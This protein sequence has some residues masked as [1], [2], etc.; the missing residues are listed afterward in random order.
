MLL[1]GIVRQF[2]RVRV[3][4]GL[5]LVLLA[6]V[7]FLLACHELFDPDVWW[8]IRGGQWI[9]AHRGVPG[10]DPFTFG[11]ADRVWV[12]LHWI[13]EV[14][15]SYAYEGGGVPALIVVTAMTA[16]AAFVTAQT[17]TRRGAF[18]V[19]A[20]V[21]W[22][23][24]LVLMS[25]R[26][27]PRPEVLSMLFLAAFVTI[28]GRARQFPYWLWLLPVLQ[29]LWVNT[30]ALFVLG[31]LVL[32]SEILARLIN[33][34]FGTRQIDSDHPPTGPRAAWHLGAVSLAVVAACL[35][36]PYGV[37]GA[38]FPLLLYPKVT[39]AG[40]IY[41]TYIAE[42][43]TLRE[44]ATTTPGRMGPGNP[45]VR[46]TYFLL[47]ALPISFVVPAVVR[48]CGCAPYGKAAPRSVAMPDPSLSAGAWLG[49]FGIAV[50]LAVV[51]A[52]SLPTPQT[53]IWLLVTGEAVPIGLGLLGVVGYFTLQRRSRT[54]AI[55]ALTGA[56]LVAAWS[57]W[58][59]AYLLSEQ[60]TWVSATT[61]IV[62]AL[63][64]PV[65]LLVMRWG[66]NPFR[67]I[68]AVAFGYLGLQAIRNAGLFGLVS[69]VLLACNVAD[70]AQRCVP[71]DRYSRSLVAGLWSLRIGLAC[72]LAVWIGTLLGGQYYDWTDQARRIGL[73]ERPFEFAHDAVR[74]ATQPGMPAR[75][76]VTGIGHTGLFDFHGPPEH[77]PYI[78]ARLELPERTTF[79]NYV[80]IEKWLRQHDARWRYALS[81]LDCQQILLVHRDDNA[82]AEA[83]LLA[84][85]DWRCV[86]FDAMAAVFVSKVSNVDTTQFPA[87]D[88]GRRLFTAA[89][90]PVSPDQSG[91]ALREAK[92][93]YAMGMSL[94]VPP[95]SRW[96][97]RAPLL[98]LALRRAQ[99]A[100]D[101][102]PNDGEPWLIW[103]SVCQGLAPGAPPSLADGWDAARV[104][105]W[106][107]ATYGFREA[108]AKSPGSRNVLNRLYNAYWARQMADAQLALGEQLQAGRMTTP[109]QDQQIAKLRQFLAQAPRRRDSAATS[110]SVAI[111]ALLDNHQPEAAS[112]VAL[113]LESQLGQGFDWQTADRIGT[114][115][116]H[117]GQ[118]A[119]ARRFWERAPSPAD[120]LCRVAAT[121]WV[122]RQ[123]QT[124]EALYREALTHNAKAPEAWWGLAMLHAEMGDAEPALRACRAALA[125]SLTESQR[126]SLQDLEPLLSRYVTMKGID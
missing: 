46:A 61:L 64:V 85:P 72:V 73:R 89:E 34:W 13:F 44:I 66:G 55:L 48:A 16:T 43:A 125:L 120:R 92:A 40:N 14:L 58:L 105:P 41:K 100:A 68:L 20:A 47:L 4:D 26:F 30:H 56:L 97:R 84:D 59:R 86:Y 123:W 96:Q 81:D 22:I 5:L 102:S 54:S 49:V 38:V 9:R 31:P 32:G 117:L 62:V 95:E 57:T 83:E 99:H 19:V 6:A 53:P 124:A 36:N 119:D 93:L 90:S 107:Q 111:A 3:A 106:A 116:M 42:F 7:C 18:G 114:T 33:R 29:V 23:P 88:F 25:S 60:P 108:D 10:L 1:R 126:R 2:D 71:D 21:L 76:F 63:A 39:E 101:E 67:M 69:G 113:A 118:P 79:E 109:E 82:A 12:D 27:N 70:W 15:L 112:Q 74:F 45:Y 52:A 17:G 24:C 77:K 37:D 78:D 65:T 50:V 75:A 87:V 35:V 28:V 94:P 51:S 104:I 8:H 122:E 110:P 121:Y 115:L 11:S 98:L 80:Q 91:A 103:G